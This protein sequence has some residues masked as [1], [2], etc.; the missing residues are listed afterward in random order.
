MEQ[1]GI[2]NTSNIME[3]I[4]ACVMLALLVILAF[5]SPKILV[6]KEVKEKAG[7]KTIV[8]D[9]GHGGVDPGKVGV[10]QELEKD[11]NLSIAKKLKKKLEKAGYIV[12]MTREEDIGLYEETDSNKKMADMKK[13][14]ALVTE[15]DADILVSIHQNS[16][17]S[18]TVKGA[19]VF[20]Y[21]KSEQGK[22]L[23][24][25]IQSSMI[26]TLD[27]ANKRKA[28]ANRDYYLLLH[29]DCP[30]VIVECGFMSNWE[31]AQLLNEE[32]YQEK[33]AQSIEKAVVN[34]F[35][36]DMSEAY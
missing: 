4:L 6:D 14:C 31:E 12:I 35:K 29:V 25:K 18:E 23:G 16:Y 7:K 9:A 8:I 1:K 10:N 2:M 30:A 21:E 27:T 3:K 26:E 5:F 13:R 11:I 36:E 15:S 28:K 32:D 24:E 20:Y 17:Q 33:I 34:Y 19:Q 22:L